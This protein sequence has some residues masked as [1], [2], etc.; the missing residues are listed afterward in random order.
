MRTPGVMYT[1]GLS[2]KQATARLLKVPE[3]DIFD[4]YTCKVHGGTLGQL[5]FLSQSY[6]SSSSFCEA[7]YCGNI[8]GLDRAYSNYY[9]KLAVLRTYTNHNTILW[10][11]GYDSLNSKPLYSLSQSYDS[12]RLLDQGLSEYVNGYKYSLANSHQS[13]CFCPQEP[14]SSGNYSFR[15]HYSQ[16]AI[17]LS[18][19]VHHICVPIPFSG[20]L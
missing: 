6:L 16:A 15:T 9:D 4:L 7:S 8:L 14:S 20:F 3:W 5:S 18:Y 12:A 19:K 13:Q 10:S 11:W 2:Q 17:L 1:S